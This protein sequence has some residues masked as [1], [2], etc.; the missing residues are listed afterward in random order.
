MKSAKSLNSVPHPLPNIVRLRA[1]HHSFFW[2]AA[3]RDAITALRRE[4]TSSK[5]ALLGQIQQSSLPL[6]LPKPLVSSN[7]SDHIQCFTNYEPRTERDMSIHSLVVAGRAP[8]DL[9]LDLKSSKRHS[10][11]KNN[12]ADS[13]SI[14]WRTEIYEALASKK[15]IPMANKAGY[16][17]YK[18]VMYGEFNVFSGYFFRYFCK[19]V[20]IFTA[21][22][23]F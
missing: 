7:L 21:C 19:F 6:Q 2:L 4:A 16:L 1:D 3:W 12:I 10:E 11:N 23:H 15:I 22:F 20:F 9:S 13:S 18:V 5:A 8:I 17:D 14:G